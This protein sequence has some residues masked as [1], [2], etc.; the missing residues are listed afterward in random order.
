MVIWCLAFGIIGWFGTVGG[1][2]VWVWRLLFASTEEQST[3]GV[4][5]DSVPIPRTM[6]FI[7][8]IEVVAVAVCIICAV[9]TVGTF[10][11]L[12]VPAI[13]FPAS[14]G[15]A[16]FAVAIPAL[17]W[18]AVAAGAAWLLARQSR[19]AA[20][21]LAGTIATTRRSR[22]FA[23]VGSCAAVLVM[24]LALTPTDSFLQSYARFL[25]G[26]PAPGS[27]L[28]VPGR[29]SWMFD[30]PILA[31]TLPGLAWTSLFA[32]VTAGILLEIGRSKMRG[33]VRSE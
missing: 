20:L 28:E 1:F 13:F 12:F 26:F 15:L 24:P 10:A 11:G 14:V 29:A 18:S 2:L 22:I 8:L 31:A 21:V 3:A 7:G 30:F 32:A 19:A 23:L 5:K 17:F 16:W 33:S 6:R 9:P 25:F 4:V 27:G